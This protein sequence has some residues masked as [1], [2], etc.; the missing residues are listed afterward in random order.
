[1]GMP[2]GESGYLLVRIAKVIEADP[3]QEMP[4]AAQRVAG[5]LG[6]AQYDAFVA[7]LR[8]Q[9]DVEINRTNLERK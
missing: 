4:E 6:Q 2:L 3:K 1:M 8:A 9:A 5:L 7:S